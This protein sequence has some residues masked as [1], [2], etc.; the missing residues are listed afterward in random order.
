LQ[1]KANS[2]FYAL[3]NE[4]KGEGLETEVVSV[5]GIAEK[6]VICRADS[7][8]PRAQFQRLDIVE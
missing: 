6:E 5:D 3:L 1:S 8:L 4:Q 2:Q 7:S